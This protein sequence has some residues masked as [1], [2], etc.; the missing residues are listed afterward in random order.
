[1]YNSRQSNE[2]SKKVIDLQNRT[3]SK[4]A[5]DQ[6]ILLAIL[7]RHCDI[8]FQ[9]TRKGKN[10]FDVLRIKSLS[11]PD[12]DEVN[13]S[14]FL[15][16]RANEFYIEDISNNI[17]EKTSIRRMQTNR[18]VEMM[19]LLLDIIECLGYTIISK[20]PERKNKVNQ[21]DIIQ[22]IS[23]DNVLLDFDRLG[24]IGIALNTSFLNLI[25]EKNYKIVKM[26]DYYIQSI[27][28]F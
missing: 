26:N 13:I 10:S 7:N 25:K 3:R 12:G 27:M 19:H 21:M 22:Y 1:M 28:N 14:E 20:K 2:Y 24:N 18:R 8:I 9:E 16:K 6:A 5:I 17:P 15:K 11:F 4:L 23:N